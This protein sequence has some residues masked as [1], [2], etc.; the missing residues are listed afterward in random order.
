MNPPSLRLNTIYIVY[1]KVTYL[2]MRHWDFQD[3]GAPSS[4]V[5]SSQ[6]NCSL[7]LIAKNIIYSFISVG[8]WSSPSN[9]LPSFN[10]SSHFHLI[11]TPMPC[12]CTYGIYGFPSPKHISLMES[13][14]YLES[15]PH[16]NLDCWPSKRNSFVRVG[17]LGSLSLN[18][19]KERIEVRNITLK[20][21][22]LA[23]N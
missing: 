23:L 10:I 2:G 6:S 9:T 14:K 13:M 3:V 17:G 22:I 18:S 7:P 4:M 19:H 8:T 15:L 21:L 5:I 20:R 1:E 16:Y 11:T 12:P